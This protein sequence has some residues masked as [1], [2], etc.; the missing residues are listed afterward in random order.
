MREMTMSQ[1]LIYYGLV[2]I[3][4]GLIM[5]KI[6]PYDTFG[7]LDFARRATYWV[8][9]FVLNWLQVDL[10]AGF[11]ARRMPPPNWPFLS[12]WVAGALL[13]A[14]PATLEVYV[15]E[16]CLRSPL[17]C[18]VVHL[19]S[20]VAMIA[21]PFAVPT[22]FFK[23]HLQL[24]GVAA[25]GSAGMQLA[26]AGMGSMPAFDDLGGSPPV[27]GS[28]THT[29]AAARPNHARV[30]QIVARPAFLRRIPT[31]LGTELLCLQMEDHYL[32][33]HTVAGSDIILYR[34]RD[35]VDEL[36]GIDGALVHR[37]YW[38]SRTAVRE[39]ARDNGR[40]V[41]IL[42]NGLR[43]P[44]SRTHRRHLRDAGWV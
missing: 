24:M 13:A 15:L 36:Q 14:I 32:R 8:T 38:V 33:I 28:A 31:R 29:G 20:A 17:P 19:Y 23:R 35:A 25:T 27:R 41:L 37:S 22:G 3:A 2:P 21:V 12:P 26:G 30:P 4:V 6:G 1:R 44:V 10:I 40:T 11:L 34:M 16:A 42:S 7:D 18:S 9:I 39:V 43:V 5:A